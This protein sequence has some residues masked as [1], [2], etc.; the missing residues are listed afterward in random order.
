MTQMKTA[1]TRNKERKKHAQERRERLQEQTPLTPRE[2]RKRVHRRVILYLYL[3]VMA[4]LA[5]RVLF[6]AETLL[7]LVVSAA[8]F[9]PLMLFGLPKGKK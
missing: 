8:V 1:E 6:D 7:A 5:T 4:Y 2:Q 9:V 3:G